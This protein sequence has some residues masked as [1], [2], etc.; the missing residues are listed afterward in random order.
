M[1]SQ[2]ESGSRLGHRFRSVH[3]GSCATS[4][5]RKRFL[6][7]VLCLVVSCSDRK[8]LLPAI[9]LRPQDE[10]CVLSVY[11]VLSVHSVWRAACAAAE[12]WLF[13]DEQ[14]QGQKSRRNR[15]CHIL[16]RGGC[17]GRP[18]HFAIRVC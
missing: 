10:C 1:G 4:G 5:D 6:Q 18:M 9:W 14:S 12:M 17:I 8:R 3:G 7:E 13:V 16:Y 15:V 2:L 11:S